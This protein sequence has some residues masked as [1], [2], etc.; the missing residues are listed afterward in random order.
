LPAAAWWLAAVSLIHRSGTMVLP[1]L[2][3]YLTTRVGVGIGTAGVLIAAYGVG[4]MIGG[5]AG[6]WAVDRYTAL[7]V[8]VVSL[9]ALGSGFLLLSELRDPLAI[10]VMLVCVSAVGEAFRPAN[11]AMLAAVVPSGKRARA[12]ALNRLAINLGMAIGPSVGGL[13]ASI[14]YLLLFWVDGL[15][16]VAAAGFL[17]YVRGALAPAPVEATVRSEISAGES[18]WSDRIFLAC[19]GVFTLST[20][21]FMQ[22]FSTL[23]VY[24]KEV[25]RLDEAAIGLLFAVNP[26]VIVLFEMV[27]V[28]RL[29]RPNPLRVVAVGALL[30]GIG[31]GVMPL[32]TGVLFAVCTVLVWSFGEMLEHPL[33]SAFFLGRGDEANRGR[34]MGVFQLAFATAFVVSPILG[35]A[36][37]E[38]F[39]PR[40]LW[41]GCAG[42]SVLAAVGYRA[43][44][45]ALDRELASQD[46]RIR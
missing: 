34:Y 43:V 9:L 11:G 44:G 14:D 36:V 39:G 16:C 10:G 26:V 21:V 42:M 7:R 32:Y 33:V 17:V 4:A 35:A 24:F 20:L 2:S 46:R 29:S 15:T 31:L 38:E 28:H 30:V 23:P 40:V 1:F 27:L 8:Q 45:R 12:V 3:L 37:Y 25:W 22:L 41:F 18:P 19:I 6:G 13:L 5:Y